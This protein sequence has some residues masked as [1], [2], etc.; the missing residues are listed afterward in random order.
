MSIEPETAAAAPPDRIDRAP[1]GFEPYREPLRA[2]LI[3][4][5]TIAAVAGAVVSFRS[6]DVSRWPVA[7]LLALWPSFGGHWVELFFLNVLRPR[8]AS[9]PT[10]LIGVRLLVWFAGGVALLFAMR[11][12]A[13]ALDGFTAVRW[14]PP[15]IG[16]LGFIAIELVV[17]AV[18][19]LRGRP[20]FYTAR[21]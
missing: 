19:Q 17:H 3:R 20:S 5:V 12:T 6:G 2:T 8:L 21:G 11:L 13:S 15:W 10:L 1:T 4:T 14:P 18:L 7:T 16:G 9:S